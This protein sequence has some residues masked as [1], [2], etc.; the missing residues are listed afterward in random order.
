VF[1]QNVGEEFDFIQA[2]GEAL[3]EVVGPWFTNFF[4]FTGIIALFSTNLAVWDM[5]GRI[6]ADALKANWLL[7]NRFWTESKLYA[8]VITSLF[9]FS[10]GVLLSGFDEPLVLLTIV[11]VLS[12]ITSFIYCML[13][14]QLNWFSLPDTVKMGK[15][16]LAIMSIAVL[17]YG[18]F[19][20][21]T[22]L[23]LLGVFGG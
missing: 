13:I 18:F 19:F 4:W 20:L 21:I 17:F 12:G 22:V 7:E 16:R 3:G 10:V 8:A 15:V 1:G 5:V 11:S 14:I 23:D 6:S 9:V 2:E